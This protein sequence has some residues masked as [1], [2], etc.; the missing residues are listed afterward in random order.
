MKKKTTEISINT[1]SGAEKVESIEREIKKEGEAVTKS[2]KST[3]ARKSAKGSAAL[4]GQSAKQKTGAEIKKVNASSTDGKAE[5][6]SEQAKARVERALERKQAQEEKKTA[7][8]ERALKKAEERKKRLAEKKAAIAKRTAEKK[9]KAEKR[10]AERKALA[11]KRKAEK[12]EKIRERAHAKANRNNENYK[13]KEAKRK[14]KSSRN[15]K[16]TDRGERNKGYGGWIAAVVSLGAVTLALGTTVTVGAIEMSKNDT[17]M[18]G[19]YRGT[20]YEL[21]GIMDNVDNDLDRV[22]ISNSPAQ[23]SRILTDLLVQTRLAEMDL[24]RLPIAAEEDRSITSFINRTAAFCEG[25]LAKLRKGEGLSST[26]RE[27]LEKL[28]EINHAVRMELDEL[29]GKMTDKEFCAFVKK[30]EGCMKS[31]LD[32]IEKATLEENAIGTMRGGKPATPPPPIDKEKCEKPHIEASQAEALCQG[33]FDGYRIADF[34]CVG[35]TVGRGYDAYNVQGYDERGN[36][37]FAEISQVDGALLRFDYYEECGGESFDVRN[38]ERIA[39]EFLEKLGYDDMEAVRL[40]ANGSNTDFTFVYEDDGVVFYPD[41][42]RIKVCRS[43]GLVSGFDATRYL[44]NHKER[45]GEEVKVNLSLTQAYTKLRE[46]LSVEASR[47]SVIK[48]PMGERSAYEF[49]CGYGE[50]SYLIFLDAVTGEEIS[51]VNVKTIA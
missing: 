37:L 47:L 11:E 27:I 16:R 18:M 22:R 6:E 28:Y 51:I 34:Q 25:A 17:A 7:R 30:G 44:M 12:E 50:E 23:Q 24:E 26:D 42:V 31:S 46:G 19:S 14:S 9:A 41:E 36:Q 20:M 33:Y 8:K 39:E 48:T 32:K 21:T 49:L 29:N 10:V 5:R 45:D 35:E 15:E 38:A 43:R 13:K 3:A 1:S 40:R 2:V 4:G